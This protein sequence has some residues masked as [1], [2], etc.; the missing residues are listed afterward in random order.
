MKH[1]IVISGGGTGGHVM[2]ALALAEEIR[3][4][5]RSVSL[6]GTRRGIENSIVPSTGIELT[7]F[8]TKPLI[9][10]SL[11]QQIGAVR[12]LSTSIFKARRELILQNVSLV[13]SVGG[14][15]SLPAAFAALTLNLPLVLLEP[16][17]LPGLASKVT[18]RF[19]KK[20]FT[21][22]PVTGLRLTGVENDPRVYPT[23]IPLRSSLVYTLDNTPKLDTPQSPYRFFVFGGSQGA[24]QLNDHIPDALALL[25][26]HL[27]PES[28]EV[29]HQTGELQRDEVERKYKTHGI[30]ATVIPFEHSMGTRYKWSDVVI[31][32]SGAMTIAELS[33]AKRPAVLIPLSHIGGGEQIENARAFASAGRGLILNGS[34]FTKTTCF[35]ALVSLMSLKDQWTSMTAKPAPFAD[36]KSSEKIVN[37]CEAFL[38]KP[39]AN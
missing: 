32:R 22:F 27:N 8:D 13:I 11:V 4:R 19:A 21:A 6:F 2:P 12:A 7:T 35:E 38:G 17:A 30:Q 3:K 26:N 15:A 9:G 24:K 5:G 23:G 28:I 18:A 31:C 25:N 39:N 14:Y 16:N 34:V 37:A 36:A 1:Q 20:I 33:L 29:V 10:G